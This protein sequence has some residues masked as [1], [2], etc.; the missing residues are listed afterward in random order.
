MITFVGWYGRHNGG[1]EAFKEVHRLLFPHQSLEWIDDTVPIQPAPERHWVLGGGDVISDFYIKR[2]PVESPFVIYGCGIGGEAE[3]AII[4]RH[5][6]RIRGAWLRNAKDAERLREMGIPARFTPDIVF[7]LK[8]WATAQAPV[9]PAG[10]IGRKRMVVFPSAN[11]AQAASR[12][13]N[14]RNYHY[15]EFF[16]RELA[17]V[18]DFLADYYDI[19]FYPLSTNLNDNDR[20]FAE[21]VASY[22]QARRSVLILPGED[23]IQDIIEMVRNAELVL[24]MKFHGNVFA[25]LGETAFVN[26]GLSR[27]TQLLCLDNGL[28]DL[29]IPPYQFCFD[30]GLRAVRAAEDPKTLAKIRSLSGRLFDEARAEGAAFTELFQTL[31]V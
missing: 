7:Q 20:R 15:Y 2:I 12:S 6:H 30:T 23:P 9:D 26:I 31:K 10:P 28:P 18:C 17:Q 14:L 22:M 29:S 21:E 16:K 1:D 24:S 8:D 13:G 5:A 3:F 19:V 25:I 27:K 4:E 11:A